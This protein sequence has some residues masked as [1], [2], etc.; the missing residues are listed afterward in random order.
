MVKCNMQV[1]KSLSILLLFM[2]AVNSITSLAASATDMYTEN[3]IIV[4]TE[5]SII[6]EGNLLNPTYTLRG[7]NVTFKDVCS[8]LSADV[9][10]K[11]ICNQTK[12]LSSVS[13]SFSLFGGYYLGY[14]VSSCL[15]GKE[16]YERNLLLGGA[17]LG[18]G[19][20]FAVWS[21][22]HLNKA[23]KL[24]NEKREHPFINNELSMNVGFTSSG[25]LGMMLSF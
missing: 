15:L 24:Y 6:V 17:L 18:A 7:R 14:G 10:C 8:I 2:F 19:V 5:D 9:D 22:C 11:K 1:Q 4:S 23:I 25:G 3:S 13:Y 12:F 20:G 21:Q 16:G